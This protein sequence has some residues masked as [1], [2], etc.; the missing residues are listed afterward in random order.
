MDTIG[1][2]NVSNTSEVI[3]YVDTYKDQRFAN[4]R[5]FI[6]SEKYT[7]PT[8]SGLKF[9]EE[10]LDVISKA[11][12]EV[13]ENS[14]DLSENELAVIP[15]D[16]KRHI[17]LRISY[18]NGEYAID[19]RQY[20]KFDSYAGPSKKGVR[21]PIDYLADTIAYCQK[22]MRA[23]ANTENKNFLAS[24][25]LQSETQLSQE[26][27]VEKVEGVPNDYQHYF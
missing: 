10:Q 27:R 9:T 4:I 21:I 6:R 19:L 25:D 16:D 18:F 13:T 24:A 26:D 5:K 14:V 7:G 20:I 1:A 2:I 22:M 11:L 17:S 23:L 8:K 15:L 12:T 3:F